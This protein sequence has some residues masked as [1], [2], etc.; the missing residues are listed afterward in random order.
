MPVL[1]VVPG[2]ESADDTPCST[3][4]TVEQAARPEEFRGEQGQPRQN[5][6]PARS[7]SDQQHHANG[8]QGESEY[9]L[10]HPFDSLHFSPFGS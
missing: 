4:E 3:L 7:G 9:G 1:R 10:Y 2:T 8:Q 5:D 6:H